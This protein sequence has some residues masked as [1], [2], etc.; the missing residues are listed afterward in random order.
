[1]IEAR[2]VALAG[3]RDQLDSCIG[4]GC[5]SLKSCKLYNP[6]DGAARLGSGARYLLGN[7]P[8]EVGIPTPSAP[9]RSSRSRPA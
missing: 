3:L 5:L 9:P 6:E 8:S 2:M 1:M 7:R 4:C